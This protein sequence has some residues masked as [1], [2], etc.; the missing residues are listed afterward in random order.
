LTSE[1]NRYLRQRTVHIVI[2]KCGQGSHCQAAAYP[3]Q[4]A[5]SAL[6]TTNR[7]QLASRPI[8]HPRF[9]VWRRFDLKQ[10]CP[11]LTVFV[12][13]GQPFCNIRKALPN[14]ARRTGGGCDV[15]ERSA[16]RPPVVLAR[17]DRANAGQY[18]HTVAR[19]SAIRLRSEHQARRLRR[20]PSETQS[21][22]RR[23]VGKHDPPA[24]GTGSNTMPDAA[25]RESWQRASG[26]S[27]RITGAVPACTASVCG[28][29]PGPAGPS[30]RIG[31]ARAV[32]R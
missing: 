4:L 17:F 1:Y 15:S 26:P 30:C 31:V 32:A 6:D 28:C 13:L 9:V 25:R 22:S 19:K 27:S 24:R 23:R 21:L 14:I 7:S 5:G 8:C 2:H 20:V 16:S 11:K 12:A 3:R 10:H 18:P 29:G